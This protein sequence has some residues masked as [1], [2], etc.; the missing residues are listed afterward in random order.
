[1][2][3]DTAFN[4]LYDGFALYQVY[5]NDDGT[6]NLNGFDGNLNN[7]LI[8]DYATEATFGHQR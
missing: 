1:M 3:H 6:V 8:I 5:T 7:G 4:G 2:S